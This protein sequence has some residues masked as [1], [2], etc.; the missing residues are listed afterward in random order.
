MAFLQ[1]GLYLG[2][3]L[4]CVKPLGVYMARVYS[5]TTPILERLIGPV[6][7]LLYRLSGIDRNR[8]ND[9]ATVRD[10]RA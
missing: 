4:A 2:V 9:V 10:R 6:E 1:L 7:R 5:G 3:L 8:R